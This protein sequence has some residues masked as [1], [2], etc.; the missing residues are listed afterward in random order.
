MKK[1]GLILGSMAVVALV[2]AGSYSYACD[3]SACSS[4]KASVKKTATEQAATNAVL[5]STGDKAACSASCDAS[6]ASAQK[7]SGSCDVTKCLTSTNASMSS[8]ASCTT[9]ATMTSGSSCASSCSAGKNASMTSGSCDASKNAAMTSGSCDMSK[10]STT[11]ATKAAGT[12]DMSKCSSTNN[13]SMTSGSCDASKGASMASGS[14]C[15]MSKSTSNASMTCASSAS[16]MASSDKGYF[17][18]NVYKVDN[19]MMYAVADGKKFVVTEKT[20]YNQVGNARFYFA[21]DACAVKCNDKMASMAKSYSHEAAE[22]ATMESNVKVEDGKKIATCSMSGKSFEVTSAT[23]SVV[24]DGQKQY[25]CGEG[26]ANHFM[27]L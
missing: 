11:G 21:D 17:G 7:A 8:G 14:S 6:K 19:G 9:G 16:K 5:T 26:C 12:C 22:L 4:K 1:I 27:G 3:G 2:L 13:A 25:F 15:C 24:I 18:A 20:P 10:C 23:P